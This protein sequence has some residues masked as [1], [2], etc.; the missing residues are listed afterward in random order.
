VYTSH[1]VE[2]TF[3]NSMGSVVAL[4]GAMKGDLSGKE[5]WRK[6]GVMA[7]NSSPVMLKDRLYVVDDTA[8]V[9]VLDAKTGDQIFRKKLARAIHSTPLV[10]DG[11]IY[12]CTSNGYWF[13]LKPTEAGFDVVEKVAIQTDGVDGSP[14]LSHGRF[15]LPTTEALYCFGRADGKPPADPLPAPPKE[16][17]MTDNKI[18]QV[19]VVPYDV[20]VAP[21]GKQNYSVHLFNARGQEI[22]DISTT[23]QFSVDGPGKI[24][25]SGKYQAPA[26]NEHQ[27][28]LVTCKVDGVVGTAR[29]RVIPPLPW[30]FD[31]NN[32]TKVPLTWLGGRVRWDVRD[33]KGDKYIAKKTVL[34]TPKDPKNKLG[35]RSYLW[36]GPVN[37][38]NYTIQADVL[39]KEIDGRISDVGLIDSGYQLWIRSKIHTLRLDSWAASDNRTKAEMEFQPKADTWYTMKLSVVPGQGESTVRGKIWPRGE[40][41]P[42]S[43]TVEMVDHAPNLRGTPGIFGNSPDAEIYLDNLKVTP[44]S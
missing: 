12:L 16:S 41:E 9:Y 27:C 42:D 37:L 36:M 22:K 26:D 38:S 3:G 14:I 39:L 15:Y 23:V 7:G 43:W 11:K 5:I 10:A 13:V 32:S 1:A 21:S 18:A 34:P 44:N 6:V 17:P 20:V 24:S 30:K 28:A 31:F 33:N 35:T 2:N 29:V 8:V 25:S 40:K 4:D 19:Q